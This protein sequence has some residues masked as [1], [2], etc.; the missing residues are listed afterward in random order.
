[1]S[2]TNRT[3]PILVHV[4][5]MVGTL[6]LYDED[7]TVRVMAVDSHEKATALIAK[8][9]RIV[10]D[11]YRKK[12]SAGGEGYDECFVDILGVIKAENWRDVW[13]VLDIEPK[14]LRKKQWRRCTGLVTMIS[15]FLRDYC[16]G[17]TPF[18]LDWEAK[19]EKD[20]SEG[21]VFAYASFLKRDIIYNWR[22]DNREVRLRDAERLLKMLYLY[23]NPSD[24]EGL[25]LPE[26]E[27]MEPSPERDLT[28]WIPVNEM[29]PD[30]EG[31]NPVSSDSY[32]YPVTVDFGDV[33]DL[34]FYSYWRGHWYN[35]SPFPMDHLVTAWLPRPDVFDGDNR[36]CHF[37]PSGKA[38]DWR[39]KDRQDPVEMVCSNCGYMISSLEVETVDAKIKEPLVRI[40][41]RCGSEMEL[42]DRKQ[43]GFC[44]D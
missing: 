24:I 9:S 34:R 16:P 17:A 14:Y 38:A 18:G 6:T 33:K 26:E 2:N 25:S 3:I 27:D 42:E 1:M 32:V 8:E 31:V 12:G 13:C 7:F 30:G 15:S 41:P 20:I 22:W 37:K 5:K 28:A 40:C 23:I 43:V 10:L 35:Q 11:K 19:A 21:H 36:K 29:L 39:L 44:Q 4:R